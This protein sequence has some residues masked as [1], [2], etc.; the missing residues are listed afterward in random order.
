VIGLAGATDDYGTA[1]GT[2]LTGIVIPD[3]TFERFLDALEYACTGHYVG[4]VEPVIESRFAVVTVS[5]GAG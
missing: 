5:V 2:G 1:E 4:A 3:T